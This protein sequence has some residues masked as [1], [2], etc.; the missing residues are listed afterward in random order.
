MVSFSIVV[1]ET[2]ATKKKQELK[3]YAMLFVEN[4]LG[5]LTFRC[6]YA[7]LEEVVS[8]RPFVRPVLF[9]NDEYGRF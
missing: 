2:P 1:Y 3:P 5:N 6:E 4:L 7:S 8:V 9:L